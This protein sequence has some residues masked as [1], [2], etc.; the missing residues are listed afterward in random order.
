VEG[1]AFRVQGFRILVRL[2]VWRE[3]MIRAGAKEIRQI[4]GESKFEHDK[5]GLVDAALLSFQ[6][7]FSSLDNLGETSTEHTQGRK[8]PWL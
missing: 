2:Q 8:E 6:N 4:V 7:L 3:N 1:N 5:P